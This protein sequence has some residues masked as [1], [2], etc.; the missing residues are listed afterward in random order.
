[1]QLVASPEAVEF[2]RRRGGR[3]FVWTRSRRCCGGGLSWL[4]TSTEP[5]E[6]REFRRFP[7]E[8]FELYLPR[9]LRRLPEELHVDLRRFPRRRVEAYWNGCAWVA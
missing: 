8:G 2:V 9:H 7:A 5:D 6:G 4:E 1:M 3:L